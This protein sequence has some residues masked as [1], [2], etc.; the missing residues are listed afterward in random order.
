MN[1]K[2]PQ[3]HIPLSDI[4]ITFRGDA[5]IWREFQLGSMRVGYETYLQDFNDK[6]ILKG[7]PDGLCPCPHWG[8]VIAGR[9]TIC[10]PE[11]E[12][13]VN[14]GE[15]YYMAPGHTMRTDAGTVLLE[16]SPFEQFQK[17]TEL[18]KQS[19]QNQKGDDKQK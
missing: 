4:P 13:V 2:S 10:Y 3:D 15:V 17:L 8:Y 7:L 12:K 14:T 16:F 11:C 6:E 1:T 9:L 18:A 5:A 19:L